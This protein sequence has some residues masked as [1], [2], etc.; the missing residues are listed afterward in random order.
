MKLSIEE[1]RALADRM[2]LSLRDDE[3]EAYACDLE[4][5]ESLSM[6]LLPY[7]EACESA[8]KGCSLS[9]MRQDEVLP[10]MTRETLLQNASLHNGTFICVP[11]VVGEG[12]S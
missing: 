11:R 12:E 4:E 7:T 9:E 3:L 1:M 8:R 10:S 5:L 2:R 6:A